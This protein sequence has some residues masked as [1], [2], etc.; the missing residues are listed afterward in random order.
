MGIVAFI[1]SNK[2]VVLTRDGEKLLSFSRMLL[3][4]A[5]IMKEHF[6]TGERELRN[7]RYPASI[8]RLRLML[9]WTLLKNMMPTSTVLLSGKHRRVRSL[10]T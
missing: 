7:F 9:L 10:M 6:G 5:D 3:E 2:G 1:R 8:I 4:Q